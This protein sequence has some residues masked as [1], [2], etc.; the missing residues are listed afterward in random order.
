VAQAVKGASAAIREFVAKQY[1]EKARRQGSPRFM[2]NAGEVHRAMHLQNRVPQVCSV[3]QS[4][5]F[6]EENGLR[7]AEK[8]GP[9]SG[10]ST[11][12]TVTYECEDKARSSAEREDSLFYALRGIGREVYAKYGGGEAYLR[13]EREGWDDEREGGSE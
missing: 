9:P 7:I 12:L 11:S 1:V 5:K 10:F 3:L 13:A 4:A 6:L 8:S 2:V